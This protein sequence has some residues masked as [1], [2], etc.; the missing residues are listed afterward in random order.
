[1]DD[2]DERYVSNVIDA[3]SQF[4]ENLELLD[5]ERAVYQ[6]AVEPYASELSEALLSSTWIQWGSA[7]D[8]ME[9][10]KWWEAHTVT[11]PDLAAGLEKL[12]EDDEGHPTQFSATITEHRNDP[13]VPPVEY[14]WRIFPPAGDVVIFKPVITVEDRTVYTLPGYSEVVF[15]PR[16]ELPDFPKVKLE[17]VD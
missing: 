10:R 11:D 8:D 4:A 16:S 5:R 14:W 3:I 7:G 17:E 13:S 1:M 2:Y 9:F 12:Y 6:D 15:I